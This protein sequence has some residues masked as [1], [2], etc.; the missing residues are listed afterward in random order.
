MN[1]LVKYWANAGLKKAP[2]L[3]IE[4]KAKLEENPKLARTFDICAYDFTAYIESNRFGNPKDNNFHLSLLPIPYAGSISSAK[5]YIVQLNPGFVFS[6]YWAEYECSDFVSAK[7]RTLA[8][9]LSKDAFPFVFL[10][11]DFCWHPG[12]SYWEKKFRKVLSEFI[13]RKGTRYT[14]L[15]ALQ[16]LAKRVACLE[17]VPY[18]SKSFKP[19]FE[20][21]KILP[22]V[23]KMEAYIKGQIVPR[24]LRGECTLVV[25]R[26]GRELGIQNSWP[27]I[28]VLSAKHARGGHLTMQKRGAGKAILKRM[29]TE[30]K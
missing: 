6:D 20:T 16:E 18:H 15:M 26:R 29:L 28:V 9:T 21:I 27:N 5:I 13:S 4:D 14:Y 11:P 30:I 24:A 10:N 2:Y 17:L 22:S 23:E 7:R 8:Q 1:T 12:F 19:R 3:H 25:L